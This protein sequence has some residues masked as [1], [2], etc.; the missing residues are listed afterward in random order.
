MGGSVCLHPSTHIPNPEGFRTHETVSV[1]DNI[2]SSSMAEYRTTA[3]YRSMLSTLLPSVGN[4]SMGQHPSISKLLKGVFNSEVKLI[5]KW[6]L[7][8]V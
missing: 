6:E 2:N 4:V 7:P 8:K 3:G 1:S 5:P